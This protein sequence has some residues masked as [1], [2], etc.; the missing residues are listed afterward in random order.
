MSNLKKIT[1]KVAAAPNKSLGFDTD[2]KL[3]SNIAKSFFDKGYRFAIRYISLGS[4][5]SR[6]LTYE[7][8]MRYWMQD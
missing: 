1:G 8:P 6:D 4:E 3:N 7:E 5:A 2:T